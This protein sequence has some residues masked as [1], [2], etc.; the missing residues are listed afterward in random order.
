MA[1]LS[2]GIYRTPSGDDNSNTS[3]AAQA[4]AEV[5]NE[6][7]KFGTE[8]MKDIMH[9]DDNY[10]PGTFVIYH[11]DADPEWLYKLAVKKDEGGLKK[12]R[13]KRVTEPDGGHLYFVDAKEKSFAKFKRIQDLVRH[14]K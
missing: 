13:I 7:F 3:E 5:E 9:N 11:R 10:Q 6:P 1:F 8:S 12:I 4:I 2:L 14:F